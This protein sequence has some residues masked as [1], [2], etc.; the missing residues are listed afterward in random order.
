MVVR[1]AVVRGDGHEVRRLLDRRLPLREPDVGA[2]D[3]AHLAVRPRLCRRPLHRVVAV[4]RLL[5]HGVELALRA[6]AAPG[7]LVE[8]R[9]AALGE[10][11][12]GAGIAVAAGVGR[13]PV[14]G[15]PLQDHG[16]R[17]VTR[18]QVHLGREPD[19]VAHRRPLDGAAHAAGIAVLPRLAPAPAGPGSTSTRPAAAARTTRPAAHCFD[20]VPS[21]AVMKSAS[22]LPV[23][24]AAPADCPAPRVPRRPAGT[25][26]GPSYS[27]RRHS[28]PARAPQAAGLPGRRSADVRPRPALPARREPSHPD[29]PGGSR[30]RRVGRLRVV[31]PRAGPRL[32]VGDP[33]HPGVPRLARP[34]PSRIARARPR[35]RAGVRQRELDGDAVLRR[36]RRRAHVLELHRVGVL[37]R[38]AAV[39]GRARQPRR[40]RVGRDVRHLPLGPRRVGPLCAADSRHRLAVLPLRPPVPAVLRRPRGPL[41]PRLSGTARRA[42]RRLL[43]HHR[44]HRRHRHV[45]R[46]HHADARGGGGPALR[47]RPVPGPD[48]DH[49][50]RLRRAV[51]GQRL[52]RPRPRHQAPVQPQPRPRR[53][54]PRVGP[55]GGPGA[56]RPRARHVVDRPHAAG[57]RPHDHVGRAPR[58]HRLRRGLDDLLLGVVDRLRS[59]SWDCS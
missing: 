6:V 2:A 5:P 12:P 43:L 47:R 58:R 8:G 38:P 24:D 32:P 10:V 49:H 37:R 3:H 21:P 39:R 18:R 51:R 7:V 9:V 36:H 45:A 33:V 14:V 59:R 35:A 40:A 28:R 52:P 1:R 17:P 57:V 31:G 55:R 44:H 41:R 23:G 4:G 54:L 53:G 50:G 25:L 30:H 26:T 34:R 56:V 16:E 11:A 29:G 46:P 20:I 48:L 19:A 27:R 22:I 42:R 13:A 15:R